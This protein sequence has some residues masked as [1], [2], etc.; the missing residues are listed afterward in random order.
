MKRTV[1]VM[2]AGDVTALWAE[3]EKGLFRGTEDS[4][5][6]QELPLDPRSSGPC[7][8][9]DCK[10]K[11]KKGSTVWPILEIFV[12]VLLRVSKEFIRYNRA[13]RREESSFTKL[14]QPLTDRNIL[15]CYCPRSKQ[16]L[17]SQ[18]VPQNPIKSRCLM[19]KTEQVFT[20]N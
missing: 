18:E 6:T 13:L 8:T 1:G 2:A 12:D 14:T 17:Q 9:E 15:H 5:V 7:D 11:K 20:G 19:G 10:K 16:P 3:T 4:L